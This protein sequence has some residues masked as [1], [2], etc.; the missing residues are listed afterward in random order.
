MYEKIIT[1]G[2][3]EIEKRKFPYLKSLILMDDVNI[4]KIIVSNKV[5][6]KNGYKYFI[7]YKDD[8]KVKLK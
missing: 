5:S 2:N 7:G 4:D 6:C 8:E 3:I 1:F